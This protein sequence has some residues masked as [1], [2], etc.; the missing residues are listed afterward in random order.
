MK[1][2][3]SALAQVILV[4]PFAVVPS[5]AALRGGQAE[6]DGSSYTCFIDSLH[7]EGVAGAA[8]QG[9]LQ[10]GPGTS[11][12]D[13]TSLW[14]EGWTLDA[15][16]GKLTIAD[17]EKR[18]A[19]T[20]CHDTG[21]SDE[22]RYDVQFTF[23]NI[24]E[25]LMVVSSES[26]V[27]RGQASWAQQVHAM[28]EDGA[29]SGAYL[30]IR[31]DWQPV[32]CDKMGFLYDYRGLDS[33]EARKE[34]IDEFF[35][36]GDKEKADD[37]QKKLEE[38][39]ELG[40]LELEPEGGQRFLRFQTY[41]DDKGVFYEDVPDIAMEDVEKV[42]EWVAAEVAQSSLPFCWRQSY[43]RGVGKIPNTCPAGKE[44]IG[45]LCYSKCP[46]GMKRFGFD[47]HSV[48]PSGF[49][50]DGLFCRKAEY[51]RGAGYP[52]KFGDGFN[53]RGMFRRCERAHGHGNCEKW[54]AIVYPKCRAGYRPF[55]CC[56]CRPA[57]PNCPSLGL[58]NG[59]DLSCGKKIQ[60]GDPTPMICRSDLEY[61][62]G[63]C[64]PRC[65]GGFNGVG[66]VCWQYCDSD[67][68][69]C[70]AGCAS[71]GADCGLAV[72]DQITAPIILAANIA[73]FGLATPATG[74]ADAAVDTITVGGKVLAGSSKFGKALV[75]AVKAL[76]TIRPGVGKT[77][78]VVKRTFHAKLGTFISTS[79]EV[80]DGGRAAYSAFQLAR[81]AYV[82]DFADITTPEIARTIDDNFHP[83]TARFLKGVWAD[84]QF[85]EMAE[86]WGW[87]IASTTLSA[88]GLVDFT[89]VTDVVNAYAK[90]IC[91]DVIPFPCLKDVD[92]NGC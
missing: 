48:C 85:A 65:D 24:D 20:W 52:W 91:D 7:R 70:G 78:T 86:V 25:T 45:A 55:G 21:S 62:A 77:A 80:F 88:I 2:T 40:F 46:S 58:N 36:E 38:D 30:E 4:V 39:L 14:Q 66:P 61:D 87:N 53:D 73:S 56:I 11:N 34:E 19:P 89:G 32:P 31:C 69:D 82:E 17:S 67:Q 35:L 26:T 76:Q 42:M 16:N 75:R 18:F 51:G 41:E 6:P 74:A 47:C 68:T 28:S 15:E 57:Q 22:M 8:I 81:S 50:D 44:K 13:G 3:N 29:T 64:Y 10:L 49:R 23:G 59:I 9:I 71:S 84:R 63:L 79:Q 43:G 54:G 33:L 27:P 60:I 72:F 90:P 12:K 92:V 37:L 83:I 1:F 5:Q